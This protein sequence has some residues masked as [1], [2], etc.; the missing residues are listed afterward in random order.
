MLLLMLLSFGGRA[1][2][3][4]ALLLLGGRALVL[5]LLFVVEWSCCRSEFNVVG[6]SCC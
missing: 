6:W 1:V 3:V 4:N 5:T 2:V